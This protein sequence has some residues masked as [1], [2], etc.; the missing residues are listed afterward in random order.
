MQ[1]VLAHLSHLPL[2][3]ARLAVWLVL[4]SLIFVP[5]ERWLAVRHTKLTGRM[6]ALDLGL[7]LLNGLLPAAILAALMSLLAVAV[8]AVI[9]AAIPATLGALPLVVKLPLSVLIA[10][11]GFYWG[12]R[13]S[14]QIPWLWRYHS[15]HH[16]PEHLYFLVNTHAHPVDIIVTRMFGL[17]PLYILG[18]AGA[19]MGGAATPALVIVIGTVWG[20]FI[21]SNL[22][23]RLGPLEW[24]IATPGFHHWHHTSAEPFNR[25]FAPTLPLVDK[26]FG[27]LHLPPNWPAGYGLN[28]PRTLDTAI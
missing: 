9:P 6:L 2:D 23:V 25:N 21:H 16:Q 20:F 22:R 11:L 28:Q 26:L 15:V 24:L 27:T 12:H 5:L 3:I 19:S 8:Q 18:L 7:Y 1:Y 14:H 17:V 10:E 13:L 4:L